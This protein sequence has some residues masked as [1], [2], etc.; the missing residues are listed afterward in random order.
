LVIVGT[1]RKEV[2]E[3][4]QRGFENQYH[5]YDKLKIDDIKVLDYETMPAWKR[6][7]RHIVR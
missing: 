1:D 4:I 5:L 7:Q 6:L 2:L 3:N